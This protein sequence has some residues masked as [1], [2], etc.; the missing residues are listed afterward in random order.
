M[1]FFGDLC[2]TDTHW[3]DANLV[4]SAYTDDTLQFDELLATN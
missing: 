2:S 1:A 4:I 3:T